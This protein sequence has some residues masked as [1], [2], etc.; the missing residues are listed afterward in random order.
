MTRIYHPAVYA[1][2][3]AARQEL[4]EAYGQNEMERTW[5]LS[6]YIDR[7]QL[8]HWAVCSLEDAC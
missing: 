7:L 8:E 1:Q 6:A 3:L 2:L 5:I 4:A